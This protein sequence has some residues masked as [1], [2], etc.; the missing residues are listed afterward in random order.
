M[1]VAVD[2][3]EGQAWN[4]VLSDN[5]CVRPNERFYQSQ[6]FLKVFAC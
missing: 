5:T 4:L 6:G 2:I 1:R 3:D